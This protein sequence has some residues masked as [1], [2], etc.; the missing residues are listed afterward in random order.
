VTGARGGA[1]RQQAPSWPLL[2]GDDPVNAAL[3]AFGHEVGRKLGRGGQPEDQL[4]GPLER[5]LGR[6]SQHL[7][8]RD[9]VAYGEV[10]L[11]DL[12][13]RP[14]Y[15]VDVG[16]ARV[17]YIELKQPG[18]G[19]PLTPGWRPSPRERKQWAKLQA[20][21]NLVYS[22]GLVWR[23]YKYGEPE[24]DA[25][26]LAGGFTDSAG[27]LHASD[28]QFMSLISDFLLC[29]PEAPRSLAALIKI[30]AGLC[31]L[32]HDE[33]YAVLTGR[34]GHAAHEHLTLL[35]EDWR[36]LLFP[37]LDDE[38]FA[39]AFAQTV[40]FALLLARADGISTD[41]VPLHEIGRL[42]GKK[43]SLIGQA[44]SVLTDGAA[45]EE[46]R[47]IG[48]LRRIL[49]AATLAGSGDGETDIYAELYERFLTRYDPNLRA[50]SGSFYTP[51]P[52]A[53]FM[54]RFADGIL[55]DELGK[56]WGLA[57]D[58]IVVDPAMG[59][60]TFLLE[61]ISRVAATVGRN[62][63]NG[64]RDEYLKD[65][66]TRRLVGFEIQ[67]APY[68]VAE[69]RLQ[70]A[71]KDE[72]GVEAPP[73][74]LRFLTDALAD[75]R[76]Q[77]ER[78]GAP[79]RV[80]ETA[81]EKAN[82]IK[83]E[84]PVM[85]VI[86]NPPHVQ[87]V[88]GRADW[89]GGPRKIPL[90]P[91]QRVSRPSLDEFRA[92]GRYESDLH[93]MAWYFWRWAC[94][95]AFEANEADDGHPDAAAGI[96][97]FVTPTSFLTGRAFEGMREYLRRE[98]DKGWIIN[99]S[100]EGNRAPSRT[101]IFGRGVGR[102]ISIA[103]FMRRAEPNRG[104]AA[105]V[106]Y[107]ELHGTR[108]E[109]LSHLKATRPAGSGWEACRREMR[110]AFRPPQPWDVH[111]ALSQLMPLRSRGVTSGRSWVYAPTPEI[112]KDRWELFIAADVTRR[113][114][115]FHETKRYNIGRQYPPLP[116]FPHPARPLADESGVCPEPVQVA[117]RSFDRQ[118]L[119]PDNRLL[120]E[121]RAGLWRARSDK[122]IFVSQQDA[123]TIESGPGLIFTGL[124]PD[125]D[126]FS[127]W[128]GGGVHP[129]WRDAD[130]Q[131]PNLAAGLLDYL[132]ARLGIRVTALD[133]AAYLAAVVA[134]PGYTAKFRK[135]LEEPGIRVP[136]STDP[137][138]W[139]AASAL[140][141]QVIWLHTYGTRCPDPTAGRPEGER[142][143][144]ERYGIKCD[145]AIGALPDR[146]PDH[147]DFNPR[148][149]TL[150]IG[151][152]ALSPIAQR[153]IEYEV[154]GRRVLWRWLNDRTRH[155]R[156]KK[157]TCAELDDITVPGWDRRLDREVLALLSVLTG[158]VSIERSQQDLFDQVCSGPTITIDELARARVTFDS[159]QRIGNRS[160][161]DSDP[162][163][164]FVA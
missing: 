100:P 42:L 114:A 146:L 61:V 10:T 16:N 130:R 82:E 67:V 78:L 66:V 47:T 9:A 163:A 156:L 4:R 111:P 63:G 72:F 109:K 142:S 37:R 56:E 38:N 88:K 60:G 36:D 107:M 126:H 136:L 70:Q 101:R 46:L 120:A 26:G 155:P 76:G 139:H 99:L 83:R 48:T 147:L 34:P 152:G 148:T 143:I 28:G 134:H 31:D 15:A 17:G 106:S 132:S 123:Q 108:D 91:G 12:Q 105:D 20:L 13:A 64:A 30:M 55:K 75:P 14:D 118:W 102:Q 122:Q 18:H 85:V 138:L 77:Q 128:G 140:G 62:L 160:P 110:S 159:P 69:L 116:G 115:M 32:L 54:V 8:L 162:S 89:I 112:L 5:L 96:V 129:L 57:D 150:R 133:F 74:E 80:I 141:Q 73:G 51:P 52:L 43:H 21:P 27:F 135:E 24:S 93:G 87:N 33:V 40:T 29:P 6:L 113:R 157:R 103:V 149:G 92:D 58:V 50:V 97:A 86:G 65:L 2:A 104:T 59:T 3:A 23:R 11:K 44:F 131:Q 144:I 35:A 49:G 39:D 161:D 154:G 45:G 145:L 117:Y 98:C 151:K 121:A 68:A 53:E 164:L 71:L 94:W 7:G 1:A 127:G 84:W 79:F 125:C 124:I 158:C 90:V 25:V 22:D 153:V 137:S 95:K 81:R 19:V 119:I 41:G